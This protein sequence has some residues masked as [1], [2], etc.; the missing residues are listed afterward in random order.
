M[1]HAN[2]GVLAMQTYGH[3]RREHGIAA[4]AKVQIA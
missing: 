1:G 2:D 3:L 4:A